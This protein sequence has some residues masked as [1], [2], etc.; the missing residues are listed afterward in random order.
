M[1]EIHIMYQAETMGISTPPFIHP[2]NPSAQGHVRERDAR[3]GV[4]L[5]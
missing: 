3:R 1:E 2:P 5:W 4:A